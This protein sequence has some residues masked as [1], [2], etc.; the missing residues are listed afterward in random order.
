MSDQ[1]AVPSV[2]FPASSL[3]RRELIKRG[4]AL[5][6]VGYV[7]P[8][9]LASVTPASAQ[10]VSGP[11]CGETFPI[12]DPEMED[13]PGICDEQVPC[14]C[15]PVVGGGTA[16]LD[17]SPVEALEEDACPADVFPCTG[18]GCET[19]SLCVDVAAAGC[20]GGQTCGDDEPI[21][22]FCL[23]LCSLANALATAQIR[24]AWPGLGS[25]R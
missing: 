3:P 11:G 16:C 5:G 17:W 9:I 2:P 21:E 18:D 13:A 10:G 14:F 23:P 4:L 15:L 20:T 25:S 7:T 1:P 22:N 24:S 12:C 19:G 8:M 6:A